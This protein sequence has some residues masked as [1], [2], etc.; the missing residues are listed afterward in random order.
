MAFSRG[1]IS[2]PCLF[3]QVG[4]L[5]SARNRVDADYT[6]EV[7]SPRSKL[8]GMSLK[9]D[10]SIYPQICRWMDLEDTCI[11]CNFFGRLQIYLPSPHLEDGLYLEWRTK[12]YCYD[13]WTGLLL[14][15]FHFDDRSF[16][17]ST[18]GLLQFC[19][20]SDPSHKRSC[21]F[22]TVFFSTSIILTH[23]LDFTDHRRHLCVP[24]KD[25]LRHRLPTHPSGQK[26]SLLRTRG[27]NC[28]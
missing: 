20:I 14:S 22:I 25:S 27:S 1:E 18:T 11:P 3:R 26:F 12:L 4:V 13:I 24:F 16:A 9:F 28:Q 23:S 17:S 8:D 10:S 5:T 6:A 19:T 2:F 15:A 7:K 21:N